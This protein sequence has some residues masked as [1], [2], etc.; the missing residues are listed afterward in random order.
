[1]GAFEGLPLEAALRQMGQMVIGP[2]G[3]WDRVVLGHRGIG[4]W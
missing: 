3:H 1:M 2:S 4:A